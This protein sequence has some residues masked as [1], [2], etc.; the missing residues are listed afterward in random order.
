MCSCAAFP[1]LFSMANES[2]DGATRI[3]EAILHLARLAQAE[4]HTSGL[5]S[6]QWAALRYFARANSSSRTLL[7][8][9]DYHATT[10]GTASQTVKKL[11]EKGYLT[12]KPSHSDGRS[13]RIDLTAIGRAL[14][15]SAPIHELVQVIAKLRPRQQSDLSAVLDHVTERLVEDRNRRHFGTCSKCRHMREVADLGSGEL[16]YVCG[17]TGLPLS[18]SEISQ[19]CASC[20]PD[21]ERG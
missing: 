18:G 21:T 17:K 1:L 8:F 5:T 14:C 20:V 2:G 12:R 11:V 9:A 10:R 15:E 13:S 7:A 3:A 4:G 19:L 6:A 16:S